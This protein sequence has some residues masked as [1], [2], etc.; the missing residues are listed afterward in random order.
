MKFLTFI[1]VIA[2][3]VNI[4][5]SKSL[6][7]KKRDFINNLQNTNREDQNNLIRNKRGKIEKIYI[8][9]KPLF[10]STYL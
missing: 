6:L 7:K 5:I 3:I 1:I 9:T 8:K 2:L 4:V 10:I